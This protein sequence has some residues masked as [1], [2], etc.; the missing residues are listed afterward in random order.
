MSNQILKCSDITAMQGETKTHFLN[1][2]A[3]RVAKS[4]GDLTG[5]KGLGFHLIEVQPGRESTEY[6]SHQ[7]EDECAYILS[8]EATVTIGDEVHL[9]AEGDFIGYPSGTGAHTMKNTG[10]TTLVCI[11]AGQRLAHDIADYPHL[12]KRLYR[13][14][15][16]SELV[17]YSDITTV[18]GGKKTK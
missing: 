13:N 7:Y 8:G 16:S 18:S 15:G 11:V 12:N 5:M 6:H 2:N 14:N 1:D 4:L 9:V 17:E 3:V 10:R